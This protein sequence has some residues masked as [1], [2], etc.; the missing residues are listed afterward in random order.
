MA[1]RVMVVSSLRELGAER[2]RDGAGLDGPGAVLGPAVDVD[3]EARAQDEGELA[4]SGDCPSV[5]S[6]SLGSSD[7]LFSTVITF[8]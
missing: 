5:M 7:Q 2:R 4:R 6:S 8:P 3:Q 1:S